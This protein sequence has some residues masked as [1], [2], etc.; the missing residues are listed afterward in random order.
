M[1]GADLSDL[2]SPE[3]RRS[4]DVGG[5]GL[6]TKLQTNFSHATP[7]TRRSFDN[8]PSNRNPPEREN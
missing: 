1:T 7:K 5:A 6:L 3:G 4:G 2:R 8:H